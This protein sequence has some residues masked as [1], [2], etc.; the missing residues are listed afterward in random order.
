MNPLKKG[1]GVQLLNFV[2]GPGVP[3]LNFKE[4]LGPTC[5]L[6]GGSQVAG[7]RSLGVLVPLL[8][9][10]VNIHACCNQ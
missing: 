5:K 6:W 1:E 9:H 2:G 4:V 10:A 8:Y 3:L 7:S